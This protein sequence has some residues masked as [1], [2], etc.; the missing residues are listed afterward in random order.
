MAHP[1]PTKDMRDFRIHNFEDVKSI[2]QPPQN[3]TKI[4]E[5]MANQRAVTLK[6]DMFVIV[7]FRN[8]Y[9][10]NDDHQLSIN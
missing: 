1:L 4:M 2:F 8:L 7:S 10:N 6:L 5:S 9:C 3:N